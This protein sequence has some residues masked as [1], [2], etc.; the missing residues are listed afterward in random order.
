MKK[1]LFVLFFLSISLVKA[2]DYFPTNSGV[3]TTKSNLIAFIK[4]NVS[5]K[6][7]KEKTILH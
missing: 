5:F 6:K 7:I 1:L 3:K 4:K 2:Q